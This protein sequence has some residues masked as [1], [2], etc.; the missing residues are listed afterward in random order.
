MQRAR[1]GYHGTTDH[2]TVTVEVLG[3]RM[4][5]EVGAQ[6]D[7]TLPGRRQ[8]GVVDSDQRACGMGTLRQ[9]RDVGD[10]QQR[11]AGGLDPHQRC[12]LGERG[13]KCLAISKAHKVD[14]QFAAPLPG[15]KQTVGA[16]IAVVRGYD[17]GA[18]RQQMPDH[19]DGGHARRGDDRT[20]A[21][22]QIG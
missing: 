17:A 20:G 1:C 3:G 7:G 9:R 8:E 18:L 5:H 11:I 12:G 19:C 15:G 10:A 13:F 6:R 21:I 16:A 2:V 22:F 14:L 4:H